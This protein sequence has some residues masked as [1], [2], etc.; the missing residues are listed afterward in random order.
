MIKVYP[1]ASR[2][3][4]DLGWL[5]S[6][7]SFSFGQYFDPDNT[8]FSVMRV[9]NH[10]E[11]D[12]GRGFGPHPHSDMEVVSIVL[13]GQIK[14]EDNLGHAVVTPAGGVQRMTA[15]TGI[16]HAEYNA[17]ETEELSLL[18]LW[19]MPRERGLAPSFESKHYDPAKL[20]NALLPVVAPEGSEQVAMIHQE[21][22]I[23]LSQ[24]DLGKQIS[25]NQAPG[26]S[27]YL[28]V[29]EGQLQVNNIELDSG[30]TARITD[31]PALALEAKAPAFLMLIDLP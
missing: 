21:L 24:L 8:A 10:D 4:V 3:Q 19:F 1:S 28:Y 2:H 17:S 25:F 20:R 11:I 29:V 30:D 9:C 22:T 16:V 27:V 23:Y 26:R 14:H 7:P 5:R 6:R 31:S 18:Q 13:K 12:A 15:G